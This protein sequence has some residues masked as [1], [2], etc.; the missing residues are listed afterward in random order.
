MYEEEGKKERFRT[1]F[2]KKI[3]VWAMGVVLYE[4]FVNQ[5]PFYN[6]GEIMEWNNQFVFKPYDKWARVASTE[7]KQ[8]IAK[9]LEKNVCERYSIDEVLDDKWLADDAD[10]IKIVND[11]TGLSIKGDNNNDEDEEDVNEENVC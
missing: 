11:L 10:A 7:A 5:Y 4:M 1:R 8:I 6:E 2:T 3:D 9:M